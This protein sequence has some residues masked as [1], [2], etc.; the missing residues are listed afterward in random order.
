MAKR[1]QTSLLSDMDS[2]NNQ[3]VGEEAGSTAVANAYAGPSSDSKR[4]V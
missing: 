4:A 3:N 2:Q 1:K